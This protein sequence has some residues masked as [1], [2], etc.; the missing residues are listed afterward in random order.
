MLID[1]EGREIY[2]GGEFYDYAFGHNMGEVVKIEGHYVT[3]NTPGGSVRKDIVAVGGHMMEPLDHS[4]PE[5]LKADIDACL[6]GWF[7]GMQFSN[8][9]GTRREDSSTCDLSS[10]FFKILQ[11]KIS[12]DGQVRIDM[13]IHFDDGHESE[14]NGILVKTPATVGVLCATKKNSGSQSALSG[15]V[16]D[17]D[18]KR[19]DILRKMF[20][21]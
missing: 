3:V 9:R 19:D 7:C 4:S 10:P 11:S 20:G 21:G 13:Q 14:P 12:D 16:D 6:D 8:R 5:A 2:V 15:S 18:K 1:I 17:I